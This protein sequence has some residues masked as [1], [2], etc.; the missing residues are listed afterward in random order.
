MHIT[1]A[2]HNYIAREK[3][4]CSVS[5]LHN[6]GGLLASDH[7][8]GDRNSRFWEHSNGVGLPAGLAPGQLALPH[9]LQITGI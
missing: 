5:L 2:V 7:W 1:H 8:N 9:T 3:K 6:V 4:K